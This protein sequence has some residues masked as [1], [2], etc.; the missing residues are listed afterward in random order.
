MSF[1]DGPYEKGD[2]R[3]RD[4]NGFDGEKVASKEEN[5]NCW[6]ATWKNFPDGLIVKK[7]GQLVNL[8]SMRTFGGSETISLGEI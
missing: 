8:M 3:N 5:E 4:N 1:Y 6:L 7:H 2:S